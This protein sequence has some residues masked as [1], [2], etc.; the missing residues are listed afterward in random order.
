MN[1]NLVTG[2]PLWFVLFCLM[3]GFIY[4][5]A[6]YYRDRKHEFSRTLTRLMAI[7]RFITVS[8]LSFF[9]L[10]PLLE[11]IS[12]STENP[13]IVIGQ[14][15]SSSIL[16]SDSLYYTTDYLEHFNQVIADLEQDYEV[17]LYRVGEQVFPLG[18]SV[19]DTSSI[20]YN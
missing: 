18:T 1:F 20:T 4:A 2:Y 15:N 19:M 11:T 7:F 10:S 6:L 3:L 9:L 13:I 12:K 17:R 5:L 16:H 14:D 8:I